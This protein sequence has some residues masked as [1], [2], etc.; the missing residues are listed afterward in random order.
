MRALLICLGV[1]LLLAASFALRRG[2]DRPARLGACVAYCLGLPIVSAL[3]LMLLAFAGI[4]ADLAAFSA[5]PA[6]FL[7]FGGPVLILL[8]PFFP[9]LRRFRP[10]RQG[11]WRGARLFGF[12]LVAIWLA[13]A[14][15]V[16]WASAFTPERWQR[17]GAEH[18]RRHMV[19]DLERSYALPGMAAEDVL[20]LLGAPD[21]PWRGSPEW[22]YTICRGWEQRY[23]SLRFDADGRVESI[24][25]DN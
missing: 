5:S 8:L 25:L 23:L 14:A 24:W 9:L 2:E 21:L 6:L 13:H 19:A 18:L 15:V 4:S 22:E 11:I 16:H 1:S 17:P 20:S 10:T 7:L 3:L 12:W